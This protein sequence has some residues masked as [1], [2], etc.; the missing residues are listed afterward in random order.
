MGNES[1]ACAINCMDG[2]VQL[3]INKYLSERF[4]INYV[5]TITMAGPAAIITS[6]EY[7]GLIENLKFRLDVSVNNHGSKVVAVVGHTD[8]AGI[9]V[10]DNLQKQMVLK[11]ASVVAKW[12]FEVEVLPLWVNE[13]WLVEE[14]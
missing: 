5:D 9:L 11:A 1:F 3:G 14:L 2:R 6:N 4:K 10:E 12:G 13:N 7:K 8:C